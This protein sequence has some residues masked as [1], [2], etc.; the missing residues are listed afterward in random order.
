MLASTDTGGDGEVVLFGHGLLFGGWMF[1]AQVAALR[2]RYRC[3]TVDWPGQG[4]TPAGPCDM[5]T[6]TARAAQVIRAVGA[7]VHWV[8]LSM[9]GFVGL[10]LAARHPDLVRSLVLLDTSA[11]AEDPGRAREH[12]LLALVQRWVGMRPIAGCVAPVVF[13]P[14]FLADPANGPVVGE[15][16]GRL[17]R[18]DRAGIRR[19]VL[20]VADRAP[21]AAEL[22]RIT[23]PTLV[24]VG[25]DDLATPPDHAERI[26][27][28][29]RGARLELLS[30]CGH[31]S[32]LE[33][34]DAVSALLS[35]FLG[36]LPAPVRGAR[37]LRRR[38]AAG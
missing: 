30:D 23:A 16:V 11:D 22:H 9:G 33:R 3:V 1:R 28:G 17:A 35:E 26:A 19:A 31:S 8:G 12:R 15:W 2:A 18:G 6:L 24:V 10:R 32:S 29:I 5:D 14:A 20:A 25:A 13:G 21:V 36:S 37:S 7:P 27:A 34:P 38:P 4:D